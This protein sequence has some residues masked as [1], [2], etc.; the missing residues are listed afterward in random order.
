MISLI[1]AVLLIAS[2]FG[3]WFF[4][5]HKSDKSDSDEVKSEENVSPSRLQLLRYNQSS[6]DFIFGISK[7]SEIKTNIE[8][9]LKRNFEY[10]FNFHM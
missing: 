5:F 10:I 6:D 4:V 1:L 8:E 9:L 7:R 2:I 3:I